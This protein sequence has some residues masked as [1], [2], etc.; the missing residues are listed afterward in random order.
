MKFKGSLYAF[1]I[2]TGIL[3]SASSLSIGAATR[4]VNPGGTGG[5]SS[6]I[7]RAINAAAPGDTILIGRGIYTENVVVTKPL[8]LLGAGDRGD[9]RGCSEDGEDHG[10]AEDDDQ[11]H[12]SGEHGTPVIRPA[13]SNPNPC[14]SN[15]LC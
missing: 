10:S 4:C 3:I 2:I 9:H 1:V 6:S 11:H 5:C 12:G 15:S 13:I 14:P 7:Q 8:T